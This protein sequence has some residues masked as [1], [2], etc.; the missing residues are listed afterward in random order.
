M[1]G[2]RRCPN[3]DKSWG[4]AYRVLEQL[5]GA[6]FP[7]DFG[8]WCLNQA[9][10]LVDA[11]PKVAEFLLDRAFQALTDDS[12]NEGLSLAVLREKSQGN[13]TLSTKLERQLSH[14]TVQTEFSERRNYIERQRQEKERWLDY[15]RSNEVALREN[16]AAPSLLHHL[17]QDYF[18]DFCNFSADNG[19]RAISK[20]LGGDSGLID[21]VLLGL[22]GVVQ[23]EDVP[24]MEEDSFPSR[25]APYALSRRAF[26][27][28]IGRD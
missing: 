5:Y 26:P 19:R 25:S 13:K 16:R 24:N 7:P 1:E 6:N 18:G 4:C 21:A 15:V 22:R 14:Q 23:R 12:V 20:R 3:S 2:L 11:K 27:G 9:V 10:A 17:A 28:W 8:L